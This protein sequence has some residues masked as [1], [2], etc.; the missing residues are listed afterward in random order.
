MPGFL[1]VHGGDC[2]AY[3]TTEP[4]AKFEKLHTWLIQRSITDASI[5][6]AG[7][8]VAQAQG[9]TSALIVLQAS[10]VDASES[11]EK[12]AQPAKIAKKV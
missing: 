12:E 5:K 1:S 8:T 6:Y 10:A 2:C 4:L 3:Y 9:K 7:G 11:D